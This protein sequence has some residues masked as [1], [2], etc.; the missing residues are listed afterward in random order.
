MKSS[1][2]SKSSSA[3]HLFAPEWGS[4]RI[5]RNPPTVKKRQKVR[6]HSWFKDADN[7]IE[8]SCELGHTSLSVLISP[9]C[10]KS[11]V[12]SKVSKSSLVKCHAVRIA[13]LGQ[14]LEEPS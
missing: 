13:A 9:P 3:G 1:V 5:D 8:H 6:I 12:A 4:I 7:C 14:K 2:P 10:F 11:L